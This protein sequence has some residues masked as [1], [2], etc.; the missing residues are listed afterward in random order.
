MLDPVGSRTLLQR[1]VVRPSGCAPS[2]LHDPSQCAISFPELPPPLG[3]RVAPGPAQGQL[4]TVL[5][6]LRYHSGS[7]VL[8]QHLASTT[9]GKLMENRKR[10]CS[11]GKTLLCKAALASVCHQASYFWPITSPL[12]CHLSCLGPKLQCHFLYRHRLVN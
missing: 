7:V 9:E 11:L 1:L 4:P 8:T 6:T 3:G 5:K 12:S 2:C 10:A